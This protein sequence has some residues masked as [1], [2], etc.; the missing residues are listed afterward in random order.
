MIGR[1][2]WFDSAPI[3]N[4]RDQAFGIELSQCSA[5]RDPADLIL[6]S[7]G[8]VTQLRTTDSLPE[9]EINGNYPNSTILQG[10]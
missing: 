8:I 2:R 10:G 5:N 3:R 9:V 1:Q 7:D 4:E 6:R